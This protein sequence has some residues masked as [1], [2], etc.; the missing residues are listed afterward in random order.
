M[1]DTEMAAE[2][3]ETTSTPQE[4]AK[5]PENGPE[6]TTETKADDPLDMDDI[7]R[8]VQEK[9]RQYLAKQTRP[10]V[11][12]SFAAW[13][14]LDKVHEIEKRLLPEFFNQ[15]LRYKTE[16]IYV[17][18]RDFMVNTYRLNPVEYL[19]VTACRRNLAG[20]VALVMRVHAF[21][22]QWGII[23]YQ[24]DPRTRPLL[25]GPQYTGHFQVLLD[26]PSGIAPF[27]PLDAKIK[28]KNDL[29]GDQIME[30][31]AKTQNASAIPLNLE[32]RRDVFDSSEDA[33]VLKDKERLQ[34]MGGK[35]F[36]CNTCGNDTTAVRYHNL[37]LKGLVCVTC[38][39]AGHFPSN[40]HS[41]DFVKM[42]GK[43]G[44]ASGPWT[45]QEVLLLLEGIEMFEEDWDRVANHVVTRDKRQCVAKF[46][47]LPI[48]D[49]YLNKNISREDA[50]KLKLSANLLGYKS[51]EVEAVLAAILFLVEHVD[52]ESA[53]KALEGVKVGL[54]DQDVS[55][56][57]VL[58]AAKTALGVVGAN[59]VVEQL[60]ELKSQQKALNQI[61]ALEVK[62]VA[63]KLE[64]LELYEKA[65]HAQKLAL[66]NEK[67][68]VLMDRLALR[69]QCQLA[70]DKITSAVQLVSADS[71]PEAKERCGTLLKEALAEAKRPSRVV[72]LSDVKAA[73][74]VDVLEEEEEEDEALAGEKPV[75]LE[76]PA[77]YTGWVA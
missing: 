24:V 68:K 56:D 16:A 38:F 42:T 8:Q 3:P 46:L 32:V 39:E 30:E 72:L 57:S 15:S 14:D 5:S 49:R 19:T 66:E 37:R 10:V 65:L 54:Q 9:A 28:V 1:S 67:K 69:Q 23:N 47:Q 11:V 44:R 21:L 52:Q 25:L 77:L 48:E 50:P 6:K 59:A 70:K 20:D 51:K 73:E 18:Y 74:G 22:E 27:V 43:P 36:I 7:S 53:K 45:E 75:S 13:F 40:F 35:V 31:Q 64:L 41:A 58:F 26:T 61:A 12:P 71:T 62:K 63:L 55:S 29:D 33:L 4:P 60:E 17:A 34:I 2:K 76:E